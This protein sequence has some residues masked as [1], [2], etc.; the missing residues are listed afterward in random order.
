MVHK[1][2]SMA[3]GKLIA[4]LVCAAGTMAPVNGQEADAIPDLSGV[5]AHNALDYL[6]PASGTGPLKSLEGGRVVGDYEN[7]IIKPW[8]AEVVK[9]KGDISK[10]GDAFPTAH[11]QCWPE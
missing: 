5:W 6:P 3:F 7:P 2:K 10:T 1:A 4:C 9:Q 8:A 11:N